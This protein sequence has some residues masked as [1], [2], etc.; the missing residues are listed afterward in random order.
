MFRIGCRCLDRP[1]GDVQITEA[2]IVEI[3]QF[4]M[5]KYGPK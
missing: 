5:D 4:L 1:E 3:L 2:D